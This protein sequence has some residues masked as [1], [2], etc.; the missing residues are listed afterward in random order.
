[1]GETDRAYCAFFEKGKGRT[2]KE[3][4]SNQL[5]LLGWITI[6]DI[7]EENVYFTL[8]DGTK[9]FSKID[10]WYPEDLQVG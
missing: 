7:G 4:E 9:A 10:G 6:T 3:F 1:V 2:M 8:Q 5:H